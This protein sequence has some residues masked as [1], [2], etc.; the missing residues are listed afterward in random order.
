MLHRALSSFLG[1]VLTTEAHKELAATIL[2]IPSKPNSIDSFHTM[3][4]DYI[5]PP[6]T[7][8]ELQDRMDAISL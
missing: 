5:P 2:Q 1:N 8:T 3:A 4:S 7:S 6:H